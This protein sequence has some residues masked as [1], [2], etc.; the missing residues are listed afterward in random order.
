M[1]PGGVE[2]LLA[3]GAIAHYFAAGLIAAFE[4]VVP[5]ILDTICGAVDPLGDGNCLSF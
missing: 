3:T 5:Q 4:L 1:R 2:Y